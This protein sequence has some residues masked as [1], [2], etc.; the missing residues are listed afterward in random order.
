MRVREREK[1]ETE[2]ERDAC[3]LLLRF[4]PL[5]L[6]HSRDAFCRF[7]CRAAA[8]AGSCP[9][10]SFNRS[11]VC[12]SLSLALSCSP[13]PASSRLLLETRFALLL[14]AE[15]LFLEKIRPV[16]AASAAAAADAAAAA[17]TA[18]AEGAVKAFPFLRQDS[19]TA[20]AGSESRVAAFKRQLLSLSLSLLPPTDREG[21][22]DA[23]PLTHTRLLA[24]CVCVIQGIQVTLAGE[25]RKGEKERGR[26]RVSVVMRRTRDSLLTH[27]HTH[28]LVIPA[29]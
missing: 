11:S 26:E 6:S 29:A 3:S 27:A 22:R 25:G 10:F 2:R 9:P 14:T 4:L 16:N 5:S 24:L 7:C 13:S 15:C 8:A 23:P 28:A 12:L 1:G 17:A 18:A 21:I 19:W 20:Y